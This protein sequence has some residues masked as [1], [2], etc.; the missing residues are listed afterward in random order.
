MVYM[1]WG[2]AAVAQY[3]CLKGRSQDSCD[4]HTRGKYHG[5]R[6]GVRL[7]NYC[8]GDIRIDGR[9]SAWTDV[10]K[11]PFSAHLHATDRPGGA[12]CAYLLPRAAQTGTGGTAGGWFHACP[13]RR[14]L[15][16]R[17]VAH[18]SPSG[19]DQRGQPVYCSQHQRAAWGPKTEQT[20]CT[21]RNCCA[22]PAAPTRPHVL[23]RPAP[24]LPRGGGLLPCCAPS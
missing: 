15:A 5:V 19:V 24:C 14:P 2:T 10:I 8:F 3:F 4:R 9:I 22:F 6:H 11:R 16:F 18:G 20:T 1:T 21:R 13:R 17:G 7:M 23:P 12:I